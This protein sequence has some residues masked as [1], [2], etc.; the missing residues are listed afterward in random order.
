MVTRTAA[1]AAGEGGE[2]PLVMVES[3]R[4]LRTARVAM[5]A[6]G[7]SCRKQTRQLV[8]DRDLSQ[9]HLADRC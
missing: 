5:I 8:S 9:Q 6:L 4:R 1:A 3:R 2:D 7:L